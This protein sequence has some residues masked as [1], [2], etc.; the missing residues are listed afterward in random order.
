MYQPKIEMASKA[1][2]ASG[3]I[4]RRSL[5]AHRTSQAIGHDSSATGAGFAGAPNVGTSDRVEDDVHAVAREAVNFLYEVLM[6]VINRDTTQLGNGRRTARGTGAVHLQSDEPTKLQECRADSAGRSVNQHALARFDLRRAMQHLIRRDVVQHQTD[7]LGGV[8]PGGDRNQIA[9]R[10]ADEL[11][12][13]TVD[14]QRGDD[15]VWLDS[16]DTVAEP[17]HHAHRSHP[18][19]NGSRGVSG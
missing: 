12:V 2:T 16:R 9:L 1:M 11:R 8:Q 18:G 3:T 5:P 6:L 10:Q 17:I 15:L 14:R 13:C 7:R 19:V 4:G